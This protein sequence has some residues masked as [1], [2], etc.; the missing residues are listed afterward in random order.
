M[1][2][3]A[4]E[5]GLTQLY[6]PRIYAL[7]SLPL[8]TVEGNPIREED[9]C[10]LSGS[11]HGYL[12]PILVQLWENKEP[13]MKIFGPMP[14]DP[15]GKKQGRQYMK[16]SRGY[17]VHTPRVVEAIII[18]CVPVIIVDNYAPPFF[19]VRIGRNSRCLYRRK[20]YRI[21]EH[22]HTIP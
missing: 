8:S 9:S 16:S 13:D 14:R 4:S 10:V 2:H 5:L 15:Q 12:R 19:E 7:P 17:E 6:R 20:T 11:M 3:K 1:L 22:S 21:E 18:E